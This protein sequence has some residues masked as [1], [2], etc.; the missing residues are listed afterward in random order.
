[1]EILHGASPGDSVPL[2]PTSPYSHW[3][4]SAPQGESSVNLKNCAGG[5][6][7]IRWNAA[8][9]SNRAP[10]P[11]TKENKKTPINHLFIEFLLA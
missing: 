3:G 7:G 1:M 9:K 6:D 4:V 8:S 11:F 10:P 2:L 5:W